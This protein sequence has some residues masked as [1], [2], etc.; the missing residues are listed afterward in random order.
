MSLTIKQIA[1]TTIQ[2]ANTH[3][4]FPREVYSTVFSN[5]LDLRN[6]Y[7]T[8]ELYKS[9]WEELLMGVICNVKTLWA[10]QKNSWNML[11]RAITNSNAFRGQNVTNKKRT[12]REPNRKQ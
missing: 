8:E 12:E 6:S 4:D 7:F 1:T 11:N 5:L 9:F 2:Y 3:Y 10:S